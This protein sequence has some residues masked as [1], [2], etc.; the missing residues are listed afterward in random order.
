[1]ELSVSDFGWPHKLASSAA[2]RGSSDCVRIRTFGHCVRIMPPK[3]RPPRP[4]VDDA[5][6]VIVCRNSLESKLRAEEA[7]LRPAGESPDDES[8]A[9]QPLDPATRGRILSNFAYSDSAVQ[10]L[11]ILNY[12]WKESMEKISAADLKTALREAARQI[13]EAAAVE[14][15]ERAAAEA[16]SKNIA[17]Q[18]TMRA[19][20]FC[21]KDID[22][23]AVCAVEC[24]ISGKGLAEASVKQPAEFQIEAFDG[25]GRRLRSGGD[26]FFVNVRGSQKVRAR[27]ADNGDGTCALGATERLNRSIAHSC[28]PT[29]FRIS[30]RSPSQF[31][32]SAR[33]I[34]ARGQPR[35]PASTRSLSRALACRCPVR[36]SPSPLHARCRGQQTAR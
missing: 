17:L 6:L 3:K 20:Q 31:S 32:L 28:S 14:A 21:G 2:G 10:R 24:K 23:A 12:V 22:P 30:T 34:S 29:H 11:A 25:T 8:G 9:P 26:T 7:E 19:I 15:A 1:M 36:P 4:V 27:V 13:E 35:S 16:A 5:A 18:P 33:Q